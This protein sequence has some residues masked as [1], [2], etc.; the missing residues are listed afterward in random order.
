MLQQLRRGAVEAAVRLAAPLVRSRRA[1]IPANVERILVLQLQQVGDT[2]I[3]SPTLV[4]LRRKY[5]SARIDVLANAVSA[6]LYRYSPL[7]DHVYVHPGRSFDKPTRIARRKLMGE[8]RGIR[9]D[10]AIA[11]VT[12]R[13]FSYGLTAWQT[14]APVR[15]G[16]DD[17]GHG[18]FFSHRFVSRNDRS[19]LEANL[20]LAAALGAEVDAAQE[21]FFFSSADDHAADALYATLPDGDGPVV[22]I[23]PASNWQ[24]KTWFPERWA[25]VADSLVEIEGARIAFV[26]TKAESPYVE[27]IRAAMEYESVSYAGKTSLTGLGAVLARCDLF[28]GTDSGPRHIAGALRRPQVTLMSSLDL[29]HRWTLSRANETVLRTD[30]PCNSC[31][32]SMCAHRTCMDLISIERV[33]EACRERLPRAQATQLSA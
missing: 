9:Y 10:V 30:P 19:F 4:A 12:Q 33:L 1:E 5:P 11:D 16:F 6:Q 7:V 22:L 32:L 18:V 13:S 23:H 3:F 31:Q 28:I 29:P 14:G 24:S 17:E 21:A 20:E 27:K 26:G 15:L 25:A 8:L 2:M